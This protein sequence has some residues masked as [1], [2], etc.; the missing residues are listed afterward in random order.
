MTKKTNRTVRAYISL[1]CTFAVLFWGVTVLPICAYETTAQES[2]SQTECTWISETDVGETCISETEIDW[3]DEETKEDPLRNNESLQM[4]MPVMIAVSIGSF[5]F[6]AG[7][8]ALLCLLV[9]K[10]KR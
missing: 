4:T 7:S 2:E 9:I 6:I 1:L 5:V 3:Y 8:I 10:K